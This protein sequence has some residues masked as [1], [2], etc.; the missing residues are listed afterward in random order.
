MSAGEGLAK[1]PSGRDDVVA[2]DGAAVARGDLEREALAVDVRVAWPVLA[3]VLK[4]G[5]PVGP[6]TFEDTDW[7]SPA[8]PTLVISTRLK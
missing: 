2:Y 7:T 1:G 3:P 5:F 8:P 4:Y 6:R